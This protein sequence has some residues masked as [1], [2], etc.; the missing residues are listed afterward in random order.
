MSY[1]Y[2]LSK[3]GRD[4]QAVQVYKNVIKR[5]PG[6]FDA[7]YELS[8]LQSQIGNQAEALLTLKTAFDRGGKNN[9]K[10]VNQYA[11]VLINAEQKQNAIS[12]LETYRQLWSNERDLGNGIG[13]GYLLGQVGLFKEAV[14][15]LEIVI[16]DN[17]QSYDAD[18]EL[19]RIHAQNQDTES[20]GRVFQRA[21]ERGGENNL[22]VLKE[23]T[24]FLVQQS[25][26]EQAKNVLNAFEKLW[27]QKKDYGD[28][29]GLAYFFG[30]TGQTDRAVEIYQSLTRIYPERYDADIELANFYNCKAS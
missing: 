15:V 26:I 17:P 8:V 22:L 12:V 2:H 23:Y 30:A 7:D 19:T 4:Q 3:A 5:Y 24:R 1:A 9:L 18:V 16:A 27:S 11:K 10:L 13:L 6:N 28:G 21:F 14:E 20:I 25:K 29:I